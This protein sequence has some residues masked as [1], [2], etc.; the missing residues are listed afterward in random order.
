[1]YSGGVAPEGVVQVLSFPSVFN[2]PPFTFEFFNPYDPVGERI[3]FMKKLVLTCLLVTPVALSSLMISAHFLRNGQILFMLI[4]LAPL[5]C[6]LIRRPK[7]A[8]IIQG[9][10]V[11]ATL[12]WVWTTYHLAMARIAEGAPYTR[13][14][15]ILGGVSAFTFLSI[16][17]FKTQ[18]L[19]KVYKL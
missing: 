13:L 16:F 8:R 10:L 6:L 3:I 4:G 11:F 19:R 7:S 18:T 1:M 2:L 17:V 14:V 12:A 15:L 9:I 5:V